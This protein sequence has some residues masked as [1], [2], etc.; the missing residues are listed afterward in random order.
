MLTDSATL[1][2][3]A[4]PL[5]RVERYLTKER[6]SLLGCRL[7]R[8]AQDIEVLADDQLRAPIERYFSHLQWFLALRF[9][10]AR[11]AGLINETADP[12]HLAT[13]MVA[14]VQGGY[15]VAR[16]T[17]DAGATTGPLPARCT[18]CEGLEKPNQPE[19][20]PDS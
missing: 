16:A 4:D 1:T 19:P 8:L 20:N 6:D 2:C 10:E 11:D 12:A 13:T 14:V 17:Q 15:V 5:E 9:E 18:Y 7:G 3:V